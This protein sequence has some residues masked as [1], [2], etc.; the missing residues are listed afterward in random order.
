MTK[1]ESIEA[2]L[3]NLERLY[4]E[5]YSRRESSEEHLYFAKLAVIELSGW[6]ENF[7]DE[8]VL[9]AVEEA[10]GESKSSKDFR[11]QAV[12]AVYGVHYRRHFRRILQAA[13]GEIIVQNIESAMGEEYSMLEH[14]LNS[15]STLR[16]SLAHSHITGTIQYI[17]TPTQTLKRF[18]SISKCLKTL[19]NQVNSHIQQIKN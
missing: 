13:F 5:A 19:K 2:R 4:L 18:R 15:L 17:E 10:L 3:K 8:F 12:N 7:T 11:E 9:E 16:N 1:R 6:I 14:E